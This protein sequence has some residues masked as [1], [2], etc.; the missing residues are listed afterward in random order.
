MDRPWD[1]SVIYIYIYIL[2]FKLSFLFF[3]FSKIIEHVWLQ[4]LK[5]VFYYEKQGEQRKHGE[6][7][8]GSY[9]FFVLKN[10]ENT[11]NTKFR[12]Q[13][14]FSKNTKMVFYLI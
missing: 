8:F 2:K 1:K 9:I 13:K 6:H 14:Q 3:L 5:T 12:N 4:I 11:E 7:M 10:M